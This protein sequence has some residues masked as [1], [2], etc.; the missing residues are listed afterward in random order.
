VVVTLR[1]LV[2]SGPLVALVCIAG[3]AHRTRPAMD[4]AML[5]LAGWC[6]LHPDGHAGLLVV[7][8]LAVDWL[9]TVH[10]V[11]TPWSI[12]AAASVAVFHASMAAATVAPP[13]AP[14]TLPMCRRWA[15]RTLVVGAA[16]TGTWA[17]VAVSHSH[18]PPG[19]GLLL[20]G[21]LLTLAFATVG[22]RQRTPG[23]EPDGH[24]PAPDS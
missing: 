20:G 21:S 22:A 23:V 18:H 10:D 9:A 11:T 8:L 19:G 3:A 12:G 24:R 15:R 16:S 13:G 2:F 14:W 1:T 5:V 6:A 17:V 4:V 7:G